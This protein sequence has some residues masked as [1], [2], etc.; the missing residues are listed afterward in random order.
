[1]YIA[2][3]PAVRLF[4]DF[5]A[6]CIHVERRVALIPYILNRW[7]VIEICRSPAEWGN[8]DYAKVEMDDDTY[9]TI[10]CFWFDVAVVCG[11]PGIVKSW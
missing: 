10:T 6:K 3:G 5:Q 4:L 9:F 7:E 8:C 11:R 2:L 1:M